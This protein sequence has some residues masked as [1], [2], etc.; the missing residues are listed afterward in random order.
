LLHSEAVCNRYQWCAHQHQQLHQ[1]QLDDN[2]DNWRIW[3]ILC[4]TRVWG[5]T[6]ATG[7]ACRRDILL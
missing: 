6:C 7:H 2:D 4:T 1:H 3:C 5:A